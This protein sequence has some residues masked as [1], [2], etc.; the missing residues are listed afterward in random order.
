[1]AK[2]VEWVKDFFESDE[3]DPVSNSS[4][5]DVSDSGIKYA[6]SNE[7]TKAEDHEGFC[8]FFFFLCH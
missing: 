2:V 6:F 7:A 8:V 5:D 3:D 1:M 4:D